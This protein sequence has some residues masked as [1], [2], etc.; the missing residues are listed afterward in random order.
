M[1]KRHFS[2]V[3]ERNNFIKVSEKPTKFTEWKEKT[4]IETYGMRE[5]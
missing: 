5:D 2:S 3:E 1:L 4:E